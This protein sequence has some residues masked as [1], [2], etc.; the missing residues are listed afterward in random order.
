MAKRQNVVKLAMQ[1]SSKIG[2]VV[3]NIIV[4]DDYEHRNSL[5]ITQNID[6]SSVQDR[7]LVEHV[8]LKC[9]LQKL[10]C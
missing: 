2:E 5:G 8:L 6:A 10:T 1:Y 3:A 9:F 7:S 4:P